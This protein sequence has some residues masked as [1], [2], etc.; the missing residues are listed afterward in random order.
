M[1]GLFHAQFFEVKFKKSINSCQLKA[2]TLEETQ[3][4]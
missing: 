1:K 4:V 2:G 3:Y